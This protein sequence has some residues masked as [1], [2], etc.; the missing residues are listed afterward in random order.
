[1]SRL[2]H[3]IP[4]MIDV[5]VCARGSGKRIGLV[6]TMGALHEG[7]ITLARKALDQCDWVVVSVFVNPTQFGANE[8]FGKYPRTLDSDL[9]KCE[10]A[11]VDAV[12]APSAADMYPEGFDAWVDVGGVTEMLE[13]ARRPGHFRGVTTVCAKFFNI[14]RPD[15]AY[16]GMK[17]YQQLQVIRKMVRDLNMPLE[18]VGVETVREADGLAMSSRNVYLS[19]EERRSALV[20]SGSLNLAKSLHEAGETDPEIIADKVTAAIHSEPSVVIDYVAVVNKD[21]LEPM[22]STQQGAVVLLAAKVGSTRLID[23]TVLS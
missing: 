21:T 20:L 7:H 17:D 15:R 23:N 5:S 3:S 4:G 11:G 19:P 18:I 2:I 22:E 6:P 13:G 12:F 10:E 9:A 14:V 1:M 8:D 16:F